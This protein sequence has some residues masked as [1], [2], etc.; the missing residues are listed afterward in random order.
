MTKRRSAL[1]DVAQLAHV[2]W[3]IVSQKTRA[4]LP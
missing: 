1:E 3:E 4:R 2:S